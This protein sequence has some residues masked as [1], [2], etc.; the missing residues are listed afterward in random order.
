MN[1]ASN[2]VRMERFQVWNVFELCWLTAEFH[3]EINSNIGWFS[4]E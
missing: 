2:C 4:Q 3:K 1:K